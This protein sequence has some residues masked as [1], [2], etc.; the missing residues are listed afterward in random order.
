MAIT[1]AFFDD[2]ILRPL[3]R[4]IFGNRRNWQRFCHIAETLRFKAWASSI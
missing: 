2:P 4:E 1:D 3:L